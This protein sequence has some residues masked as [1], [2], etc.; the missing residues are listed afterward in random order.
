MARPTAQQRL[1]DYVL[2]LTHAVDLDAFV[3]DVTV[4]PWMITDL[5]AAEAAVRQLRRQME[6]RLAGTPRTCA[7]C[8]RPL[9]GRADRRYC[10]GR[11]RQGA[12][13]SRR[14]DR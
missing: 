5:R 2:S 7:G 11:C 10:S 1:T 3:G 9:A 8:G 12:L 14:G 13:R 4:E 6:Q